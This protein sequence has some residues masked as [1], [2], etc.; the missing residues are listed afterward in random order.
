MVALL[1]VSNVK[2]FF[3]APRG[4]ALWRRAEY[5]KAV[6]DVSFEIEE[7]TT[8]GLVGESGSGKTTLSRLL[9]M[10]QAPTGG[11]IRFAGTDL[12]EFKRSPAAYR[13][14]VQA[15]F[16]D[17]YSSLNPRMTVGDL[18]AEPV[19]VHRTGDAAAASRRVDELLDLVGLSQR[20]RNLYPHEFS[21]GQRQ[22][23]AIARALSVGPK[24]IVFDEPVSA[25]DVSIRAQI[26]NLLADIQ[27]RLDLT[28]LLIAHDLA[29]VEHVSDICGVMYLGRLVEIC[30][31]RELSRNPLHPYTQAL[32][33]AV[34]VPDPDVPEP[35]VVAGETPSPLNPPSGCRFHT[36]CPSVI[37]E[38]RSLD[39]VLREVSPGH[40]A[41]CHLVRPSSRVNAG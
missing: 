13:R 36:R 9:L 22:R 27:R 33:A 15:V 16:Q 1:Q 34:P 21:G 11:S 23:V 10:L 40:W 32:I 35:V 26:L 28:Y 24:F 2:K 12:R 17:P 7:G 29:V 38:C 4:W 37:A 39:P 30:P 5:L 3:P 31:S 8:F 41:A 25:L 6:D 14:A 20:S 18:L 19:I